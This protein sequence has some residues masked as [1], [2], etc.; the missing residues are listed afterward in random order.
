MRVKPYVI[1]I[2]LILILVM[3]NRVFLNTFNRANSYFA[4]ETI[5]S[6]EEVKPQKLF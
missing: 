2:L 5:Y 4:T 3:F 1:S 6:N